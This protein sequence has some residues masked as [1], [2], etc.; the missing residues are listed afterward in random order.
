MTARQRTA[1]A[2]ITAYNNSTAYGLY[3]VYD[4]FSQAKS[5][6]W[7]YCKELCNKYN[8]YALKVVSFNTFMFTA[9][10]EFV[11]ENTGVVM[12]MHI[13]PNYDTAVEM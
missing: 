11:D 13:T 8:G 3:D 1:K 12:Y 2:N 6:A 9:G 10:F 5:Q 4:S 7:D